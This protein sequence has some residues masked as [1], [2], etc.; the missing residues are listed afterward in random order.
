VIKRLL[1]MLVVVFIVLNAI[2]FFHAYQFTHFDSSDR[3]K[4]RDARQLSFIKK[5]GIVF[6]GID[7]PRPHNKVT[8]DHQFETIRLKSNKEIECWLIKTGAPKGT[9]I[10]FHGYGGEKSS[11]LDKANVFQSLGYSTM[12]V[13][14]MGAGG[15]EG[16][17]TTIGFKEACE[18]KT[19]VEF[20]KE[21]GE[22]NIVLFG[23]SLGAAAIMKAMHDYQ[24]QVNSII[25][26]CPFGT[27]LQ[28]VENRFATMNIPSF[29]M[30]NLLVF[31][32]GVQN[33]FNAFSHNPVSYA[34][35]INCPTLLF[36]GSKDEKVSAEETKAIFSNLAGP[37]KMVT[38]PLARHENYLVKYQDLWTKEISAFL[39]IKEDV[40][41]RKISLK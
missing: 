24:L 13:D 12:L 23:T 32:G 2:A 9:V 11:M 15:S 7:N 28:T 8:P 31:W 30:A 3:S 27:M 18:V 10:L 21:K 1:W 20:L 34:L 26:E 35:K 22:M 19:C 39:N 33:G 41:I 17:Q 6:F 29:P 40:G 38:F 5:L 37:K 4:T 25:I 16:N 14:F 36:Y